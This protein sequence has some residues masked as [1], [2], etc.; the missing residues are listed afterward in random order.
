MFVCVIRIFVSDSMFL[1][2]VPDRRASTLFEVMKKYIRPGSIITVG[3]N[4][5]FG[6][7]DVKKSDCC[8]KIFCC[9]FV[10]IISTDCWKGYRKKDFD[11]MEWTYRSVNHEKYWVNKCSIQL[12]IN[13]SL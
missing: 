10:I 5:Y 9:I 7:P 12:V 11:K 13:I 4:V 6:V 8:L 1:V 3:R 2:P